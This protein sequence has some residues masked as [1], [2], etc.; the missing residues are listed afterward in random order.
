MDFKEGLEPV[1][2]NGQYFNN[3]VL[4]ISVIVVLEFEVPINDL[5]LMSL[6]NVNGAW[7]PINPRFSSVMLL[8][9]LSL[10]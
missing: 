7:L 3:S 1:S 9:S 8:I 10:S 4:S 2:P 5:P 6:P